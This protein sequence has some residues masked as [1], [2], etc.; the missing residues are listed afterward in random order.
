M[1]N[2]FTKL[3]SKGVE[4]QTKYSAA[5]LQAARATIP[6]Q[7]L[8]DQAKYVERSTRDSVNDSLLKE[9]VLKT[10]IQNMIVWDT[11]TFG[12]LAYIAL[13]CEDKK[14]QD[15]AKKLLTEYHMYHY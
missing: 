3:F 2:F 1:A 7:S 8:Q 4:P 13:H 15:K 12:N 6:Y 10:T 14:V 9:S 5:Q 11:V